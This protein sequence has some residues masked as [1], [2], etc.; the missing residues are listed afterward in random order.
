[1]S[2]FVCILWIPVLALSCNKGN[3]LENDERVPFPDNR[4][5]GEWKYTENYVSPGTIWHWEKVDN[6]ATLTINENYTY[7]IAGNDNATYW[8]F[9]ILGAEGKL[10]VRTKSIW[11]SNAT[12]FVKH[13]TTDSVFFHP[14]RINKDTLELAGFCIEGCIYRF[15]K[16]NQPKYK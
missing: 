16:I 10:G 13:G 8:P 2:K 12:Y 14:V 3:S 11:G 1:M 9:M 15:M 6:G 5:F 4:I 7:K